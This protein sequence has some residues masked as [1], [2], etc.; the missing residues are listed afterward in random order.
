LRDL[1][2]HIPVPVDVGR[3]CVGGAIKAT[4]GGAGGLVV[5]AG[6]ED[7]IAEQFAVVALMILML[8]SWMRIRGR[9]RAWVRPTP[10]WCRPATRNVTEPAS[11]TRSVRT[12]SWVSVRVP[13]F[14]LGRA[15]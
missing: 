3:R 6:V 11:S 1:L 4:F 7:Q 9:V 8:R 5:A 2:G 14:A 12:R 10:M 13:G 15:W